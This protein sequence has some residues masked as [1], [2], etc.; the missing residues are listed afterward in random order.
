MSDAIRAQ[1]VHRL[2]HG[3]GAVA[4]PRMHGHGEVVC[5]GVRECLAVRARGMTAL[6]AREIEADD[7]AMLVRDRETRELARHG[8]LEMPERA[9]DQVRDGTRLERAGCDPAQ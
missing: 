7:A 4:L 6:A 2:S 8:R 9:D 1:E 5:A 3:I